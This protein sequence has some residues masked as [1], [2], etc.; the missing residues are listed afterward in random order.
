MLDWWDVSEG[1]EI[2]QTTAEAAEAV[3]IC[4]TE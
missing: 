4:L 3:T 2:H 1:S